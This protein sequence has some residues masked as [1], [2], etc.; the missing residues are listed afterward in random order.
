MDIKE[1]HPIPNYEGLYEINMAGQIRSLHKRNYQNLIKQKIDRAGYITVTLCKKGKS[2]T[3]FMHRL[4][5]ITYIPNPTNRPQ[6][7]HIN[8]NKLDNSL[9][10]LEWVTPQENIKHAFLLGLIPRRKIAVVDN[11]TGQKFEST[12]DAAKY[13][14]INYHTM[15]NYLTGN[16]KTNPTCAEYFR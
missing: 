15:K 3:Y 4:L 13:Y 1:W 16:I 8:G 6:I 5:A 12:R 10:N 14:G 7:N 11:C 9:E 2:S